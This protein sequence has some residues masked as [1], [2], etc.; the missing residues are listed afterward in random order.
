MSQFKPY[1]VIDLIAG[2]T[3][4]F[5]GRRQT[6]ATTPTMTDKPG[7]CRFRFYGDRKDRFTFATLKASAVVDPNALASDLMNRLRI[8]ASR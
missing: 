6:L 3:I 5:E 1:R 2:M 7:V 8:A 4:L